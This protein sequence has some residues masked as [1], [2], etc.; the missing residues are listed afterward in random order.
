MSLELA[1][2]RVLLELKWS[3]DAQNVKTTLRWSNTGNLAT[4]F[5][6]MMDVAKRKKAPVGKIFEHLIRKADE[7]I[8]P[9]LLTWE[10]LEQKTRDWSKGGAYGGEVKPKAKRQRTKSATKQVKTSKGTWVFHPN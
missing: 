7:L 6:E 8:G 9:G 2:K 10:K 1:I 4:A 5:F 3:F